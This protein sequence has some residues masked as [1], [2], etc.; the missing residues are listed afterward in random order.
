MNSDGP[1]T[2][3]VTGIE[4]FTDP[5]GENQ[6]HDGD[7]VQP[8]TR[9][10]AR[11][12]STTEP[13]GF[14]LERVA[15]LLEGTVLL[16]DGT[17]PGLETAQKLILARETQLVLRAGAVLERF[18]AGGLQIT[19]RI[20][21][22][23]AGHQGRITID[24]ICRDPNTTQ[25]QHHT[26]TFPA[27]ASAGEHSRTISGIPAGSTCTITEPRGGDND[28]VHQVGDPVIEPA[29]VTIVGRDPAGDRH[30]RLR[31]VHG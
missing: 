17:N 23:G 7:V 3:H 6:L 22:D 1:A 16:Y 5:N 2:I 8:G 10:W 14:V 13:Q 4:V 9:L 18:A 11:S 15:T 25:E 31:A 20:L 21:G 12:T 29:T 28:Q 30:R 24:V 27:G 19:K 26:V